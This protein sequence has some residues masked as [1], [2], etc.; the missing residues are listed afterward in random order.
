MTSQLIGH[1]H[2]GMLVL[3]D[4][5]LTTAAL[6]SRIAVSGAHLLGRCK[7]NRTL[8]RVGRLPDGSWL[9]LL[10][11]VQV[12]VIEAEITIATRA[13]RAT[14]VYRLVTTLTNPTPGRRPPWWSCTT[15]AGRSRP[16]TWS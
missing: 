13:G 3:C 10:G 14:G 11:R 15:S 4:R 9:S 12:R 16:P 7:A 6:T 5:N 2:P 1:L 8:P